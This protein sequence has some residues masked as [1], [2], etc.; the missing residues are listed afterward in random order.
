[1]YAELPFTNADGKSVLAGVTV[2][3]LF[4]VHV[5]LATTGP[6][7]AAAATTVTVTTPSKLPFDAVAKVVKFAALVLL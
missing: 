1:M 5:L 7:A 6:A 2:P 4:V 3:E